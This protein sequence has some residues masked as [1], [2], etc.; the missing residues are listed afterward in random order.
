MNL[1]NNKSFDAYIKA[2]VRGVCLATTKH[3]AILE[4]S[5]SFGTER[6]QLWENL[7]TSVGEEVAKQAV[8][9]WLAKPYTLRKEY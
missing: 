5:T 2:I 1:K 3:E 4:G 9:E 6:L 8:T 7:K